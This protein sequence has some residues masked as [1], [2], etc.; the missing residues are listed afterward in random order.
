MLVQGRAVAPDEIVTD[1]STYEDYW[2]TTIMCRQP[3]SGFLSAWPGWLMAWMHYLRIAITVTP[4]RIR[5][6]ARAT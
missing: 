4:H 6:G 5:Y 1:L 3:D 2:L